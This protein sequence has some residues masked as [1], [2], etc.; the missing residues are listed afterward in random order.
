MSLSERAFINAFIRSTTSSLFGVDI[1]LILGL[2]S[3]G[4]GLFE[5]T[6]FLTSSVPATVHH[7]SQ[8]SRRKAFVSVPGHSL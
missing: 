2:W 1:E 3:R 7:S 4:L 6:C 8:P 5:E